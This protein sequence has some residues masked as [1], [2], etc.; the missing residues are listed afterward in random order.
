[1]QAKKHYSQGAYSTAEDYKSQ[2]K[3]SAWIGIAIGLTLTIVFLGVL[4]PVIVFRA[5]VD[6]QAS[7]LQGS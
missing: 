2:A 3:K 5:I 6:H 7:L 1:M 4:V